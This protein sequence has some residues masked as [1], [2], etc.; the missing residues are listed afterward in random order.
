M[1]LVELL[2]RH[3]GKAPKFERVPV[4]LGGVLKCLDGFATLSAKVSERQ[5]GPMCVC[6]TAI[7]IDN[8]V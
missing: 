6:L 5:A 1:R 2:K 8:I 4:I 7:V 3:E